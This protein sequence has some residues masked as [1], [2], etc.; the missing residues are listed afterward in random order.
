MA[1]NN[2][3]M[4]NQKQTRKLRRIRRRETQK[5]NALKSG[6]NEF[7]K[8]SDQEKKYVDPMLKAFIFL[9]KIC[10]SK[11][12]MTSI[13]INKDK[14][15]PQP[16]KDKMAELM[17]EIKNDYKTL[18]EAEKFPESFKKEMDSLVEGFIKDIEI[19]MKAD[20]LPEFSKKEMDSLIKSLA[21]DPKNHPIEEIPELKEQ[22]HEYVKSIQSPKNAIP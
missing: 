21:N 3:K 10:A 6:I 12:L 15:M 20:K 1:N 18:T 16:I 8:Y 17:E 13:L 7:D 19:L 4:E 2:K 22:V 9:E 14:K 5:I 11:K